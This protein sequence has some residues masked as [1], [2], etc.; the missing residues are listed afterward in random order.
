MKLCYRRDNENQFWQMMAEQP[1]HLNIGD[2]DLVRGQAD[3]TYEGIYGVAYAQHEF[4]TLLFDRFSDKEKKY[5]WLSIRNQVF[6]S[7]MMSIA[8]LN[9]FQDAVG[10]ECINNITQLELA[11]DLSFNPVPRIKKLLKREDVAVVRCGAKIEDKKQVIDGLF[12]LHP[13]SGLK[14]LAPTMYFSDT[15]KRKS[16][17]VYDK[18]KEIQRSNKAYIADYYGNPRR[19][20]RME[21]RLT[22]DELFRYFQKYDISPSVDL[23][24][25]QS[26][27]KSMYDEFLFRLFHFSYRRKSIGLLDAVLA[28][29]EGY[30]IDVKMF[31]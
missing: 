26:F 10:F 30:D 11:C 18:K 25:D 17:V 27:L 20:Y 5:C 24:V 2:F 9:E 29:K 28:M 14:E 1:D 7:D 16:F 4:G 3:S 21:I 13:T 8:L 19:L 6:Y 15:D 23:L 12:F 22:S 31:P